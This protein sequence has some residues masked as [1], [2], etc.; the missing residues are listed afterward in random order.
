M[1][2]RGTNK[3]SVDELLA[4][5]DYFLGWDIK[6]NQ[7]TLVVKETYFDNLKYD[8]YCN[9]FNKGYKN[10]CLIDKQEQCCTIRIE[11]A[12][13][14]FFAPLFGVAYPTKKELYEKGDVVIF[15]NGEKDAL[16]NFEKNEIAKKILEKQR[17]RSLEKEVLQNLINEGVIMQGAKREPIPREISDAVY[18]RD[19]GKCVYCGST[20]SLQ[21]DHIIP[22]SKG[23]ATS[24]ENLQLL[25][26]KCNASK[27]NK[28]G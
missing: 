4:R 13:V 15:I 28:I 2:Y 10:P 1:P 22:Y 7:A 26:Q 16:T 11:S 18:S 17:K 25:C 19:K 21:F 9:Y 23:G 3:L 27:S 5:K 14:E 8:I 6:D 12:Y 24:V 20:E